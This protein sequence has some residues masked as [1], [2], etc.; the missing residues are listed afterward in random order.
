MS[1]RP[2][3]F[4]FFL[5]N[6]WQYLLHAI[7]QHIYKLSW[8]YNLAAEQPLMEQPHCQKCCRQSIFMCRYIDIPD[9]Q[10]FLKTS[11]KK[12]NLWHRHLGRDCLRHFLQCITRRPFK[13]FIGTVVQNMPPHSPSPAAKLG[14][15]PIRDSTLAFSPLW[16]CR[17]H[18]EHLF[19]EWFFWG[20]VVQ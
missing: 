4:F 1:L 16:D 5:I 19:L 12:I 8:L 11:P 13:F 18:C 15:T 14:R 3:E 2:Y 10:S 9:W 17:H 6:W 20:K 7:F